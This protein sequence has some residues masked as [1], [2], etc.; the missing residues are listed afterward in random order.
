MNKSKCLWACVLS[1]FTVCDVVS[2][3]TYIQRTTN[4]KSFYTINI[5]FIIKNV[6]LTINVLVCVRE[7]ER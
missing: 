6:T 1:A 4:S 2:Y 5:I 3:T 7:R